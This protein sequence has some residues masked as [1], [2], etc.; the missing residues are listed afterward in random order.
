MRN[1]L[2]SRG[3]GAG[4]FD[5]SIIVK[6]LGEPAPTVA[7]TLHPYSRMDASAVRLSR[8]CCSC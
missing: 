2:V 8:H 7:A 1:W 6:Y 4:L 5:L 3:V